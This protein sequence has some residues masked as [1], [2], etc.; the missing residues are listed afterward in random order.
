MGRRRVLAGAAR[1]GSR[2]LPNV[3]VSA[4]T[5]VAAAL[6]ESVEVDDCGSR[7]RD[8]EGSGAGGGIGEDLATCGDGSLESV[9]QRETRLLA[10]LLH[11]MHLRP[12]D[13]AHVAF[14]GEASGVSGDTGEWCD[15]EEGDHNGDDDDDND[16]NDDDGGDPWADVGPAAA[17][18][19]CLSPRLCPSPRPTRSPVGWLPLPLMPA[20]GSED[21]FLLTAAPMPPLPPMSPGRRAGSP[22]APA[23]AVAGDRPVMARWVGP[24]SPTSPTRG[25]QMYY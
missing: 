4:A 7:G 14:A 24:A 15:W 9:A 12:V 5:Q 25:M 13:N 11:S 3:I 17:I 20:V 19:L 1:P 2:R 6:R 21:A 23:P 18:P 22:R 16:D 10:R 8:G